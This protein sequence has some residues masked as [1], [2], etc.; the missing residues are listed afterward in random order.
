MI[1]KI[2]AITKELMAKG[3]AITWGSPREGVIAVKIQKRIHSR[4]Y[5]DTTRLILEDDWMT[6]S[7]PE[8]IANVEDEFKRRE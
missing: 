2:G 8:F 3:C 1:K 4:R 6:L 5:L 7:V